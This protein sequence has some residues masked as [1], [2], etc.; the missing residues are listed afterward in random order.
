MKQILYCLGMWMSCFG[1]LAQDN[2]H[3]SPYLFDKF[4]D[5]LIVYKDGRQFEAPINY[6]LLKSYFVFIDRADQKEK[7]FS[8]PELIAV[9]RIGGR[10]FLPNE[11]SATEVIQ[12]DPKFHVIYTGNIRK[13]PKKTSYGGTT[14]TAPV[15]NFSGLSGNGMI[16]GT[17][18]DNRIV[19]SINKT[20][21]VKIG[22]KTKRFYNKNSF[23]KL[24]SNAE[25]VKLDSYIK[26]N[27]IDFKSVEQVLELYNFSLSK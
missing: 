20:Y 7:E 10:S 8:N 17:R 1:L 2:G 15:D 3:N 27:H 4:Q 25:Q 13:A 5:C 21:E 9:L 16:S 6:H 23:L 22:K 18:D 26:T 24:Y 14:Q 11:R 19:T 12:A